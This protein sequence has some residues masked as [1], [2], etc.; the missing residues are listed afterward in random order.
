MRPPDSRPSRLLL[1]V[2][3]GLIVLGGYAATLAPSV[4]FWDAGEFI[5][6]SKILGIP[7][8]PGTPLFVLIGHVWGRLVPLADYAE[9]LNL[10]SAVCA[11]AAAGAFFLVC[12]ETLRRLAAEL[13]PAPRRLIAVGG[14]VAATLMSAFSFTAWQNSNETEVYA[15]AVFTIA[16]TC[17]LCHLWREARGTPRAA[18]LL[19]LIV[20]LNG[21]SVGAHLLALLAGPAVM[22]FVFVTLRQEPADDEGARRAELGQ[23]AVLAGVWALLVGTGLGSTTLVVLGA[24]VFAG[25]AAFAWRG[26]ASRFALLALVV[27][28]VGI[29]TYG[30]LY[31]RAAQHPIINE[32]QPDNLHALLEVIRRAQYPV[33]T[34][35]DDP[36]VY[37]G[38]DNPGRSP[39]ILGLQFINYFQYFDWQWANGLRGGIALPFGALAWRSV[40]TVVCASLGLSGLLAQR[41]ADRAAWWL[42]FTLWL[43]TGVALV[44]YMNFKPGFSLGFRLYPRPE[45]HEVRERDYFFVMS[46]MVWG[47]WAGMGLAAHL[48]R[49]LAERPRLLPAAIGLLALGGLIPFLGNFEVAS[50]RHIPDASLPADFAFSL[51]NSVPPYGILFTYG[52][53]D[54][55]PLWWAQ[56]V[57]GIRQD[58]TVI[59][60]SLANTTW[61]MRQLRAN[62]TR[63][64][65]EAAAPA[66]WRGRHPVRPEGPL[67]TLSDAQ[68]DSM[69]PAWQQKPLSVTLGPLRAEIPGGRALYPSD[70][71]VLRLV[72][73]NVGRRPIAWSTTTGRDFVGLDRYLVQ[74]GLVYRLEAVPTD[75]DP[76]WQDSRRLFGNALDAA[77]SDRLLW[78]TYRYAGLLSGDLSRLDPT[79][80]GIAA[81]LSFPFTQLAFL[82]R[83]RGDNEHA[84]ANLGRAEKL[85]QSADIQAALEQLRADIMAGGTQ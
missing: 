36:T 57:Q 17:W 70:I 34:P 83:A 20:Y 44:L 39:A 46:F 85:A 38:P 84:L 26:G 25:A 68:I 23:L 74:Q 75:S 59:C 41:K 12:H 65:D 71:L 76:A 10:L 30:Y 80:R 43:T 24:L 63:P 2:G 15:F 62:P 77:T 11:A 18:N 61:Y 19:L 69:K 28:A 27:A 33:R 29:T 31:L 52:D 3:A 37:H 58:V 55:F 6:A 53:N 81:N 7:H 8:P 47:L 9:R 4:T 73:E 79:S 40:L 54:T 50:R 13:E 1:A 64:F 22:M 66:V 60:L 16:L 67:H 78:Q 72:Q 48:K 32:A 5:A 21:I 51:L 14:A 45:D 35:F 42:L 82:Y 56:E 49:L